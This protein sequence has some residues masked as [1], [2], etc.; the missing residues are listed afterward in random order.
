MESRLESRLEILEQT[1]EILIKR[2][3]NQDILIQSFK[4]SFMPEESKVEIAKVEVDFSKSE[5]LEKSDLN[6]KTLKELKSLCSYYKIKGFS[7]CNKKSLIELITPF[8]SNEPEE[9]VKQ[10]EPEILE[11]QEPEPEIVLEEVQPEPEIVLEEVQPE[12]EIVLEEVKQPETVVDEVDELDELVMEIDEKLLQQLNRKAKSAAK[13]GKIDIVKDAIKNGAN[14]FGDMIRSAAE[15][16]HI[17]IVTYLVEQKYDKSG[18][19]KALLAAAFKGHMNIVKE[20]MINFDTPGIDLALGNAALGGHMNMVQEIVEL[21]GDK[22]TNADL[23]NAI[24]S[25]KKG[26]PDIRK[27]LKSLKK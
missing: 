9:E 25:T 11:V 22:L 7:K 24:S 19:Y 20:M 15:N 16:G 27:F 1:V 4:G 12:P 26:C 23:D 13:H 5:K 8:I 6:L 21:W 10:P 3:D 2:L 18:E 17:E 14:N